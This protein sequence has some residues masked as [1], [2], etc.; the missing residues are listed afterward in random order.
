MKLEPY[1]QKANAIEKYSKSPTPSRDKH[2]RANPG[3]QKNNKTFWSS[4][5]ENPINLPRVIDKG[6]GRDITGSPTRGGNRKQDAPLYKKYGK[7][8][9]E[10]SQEEKKLIFQQQYD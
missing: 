1:K 10:I 9:N 2:N 3:I 8:P 6:K 4:G 7:N 5:V